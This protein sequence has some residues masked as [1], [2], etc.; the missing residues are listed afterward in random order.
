VSLNRSGN[1][2]VIR[3]AE[4]LSLLLIALLIAAG[5][6]ACR[7]DSTPAEAPTITPSATSANAQAGTPTATG[8]AGTETATATSTATSKQQSPT[9]TTHRTPTSATSPTSEPASDAPP[10]VRL[11]IPALEIDTVVQ[12]VGIDAEGR[13][14]VPNNYTDVAWYELGPTPGT[15]G[16]AVI[17][18]HLDSKSGPA[19]FYHLEDLVPGDEIFTT[20]ADGQEFRFVVT[21]LETYS[22]DDAPLERIFGDATAPQLNL[23]T[24]DGAFD[25]AVREYDKRLVV[26][27]ELA[28]GA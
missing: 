7:D 12:W 10:P 23:I 8:P 16:N 13:M 22:A 14:G 15:P 20:T 6:I 17:A 5:A 24:C 1:S 11:R 28:P 4:R 27:A 9:T 18:G 19:V 3:H 21:T 25:R 2:F 26:Y